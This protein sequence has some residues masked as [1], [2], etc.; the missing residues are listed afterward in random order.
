MGTVSY[1][2][3]LH[4]AIQ[5]GQLTMVQWEAA[6]EKWVPVFTGKASG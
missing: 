2:P 5:A 6:G 1:S 4:T 3:E